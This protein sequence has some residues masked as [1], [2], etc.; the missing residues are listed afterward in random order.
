M[1][2]R[3][4]PDGRVEPLA[5]LRELER[6]VDAHHPAQELAQDRGRFGELNGDPRAAAGHVGADAAHDLGLEQDQLAA[7]GQIEL[8][9]HRL[10]QLEGLLRLHEGAPANDV[11][12]E[13]LP[14]G[15]ERREVELQA[16][17]HRRIVPRRGP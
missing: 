1:R 16:L 9:L 13:L 3:L 2:A 4:V 14:E 8:H 10:S 6:R 5:A 15:E 7:E 17:W 12:L 11:A